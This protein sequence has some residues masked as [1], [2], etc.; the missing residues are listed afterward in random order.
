MASQKDRFVFTREECCALCWANA[1]CHAA[2]FHG[3][4][5]HI[6]GED[7][8]VARN[9]GSVSCVPKRDLESLTATD[10]MECG[11]STICQGPL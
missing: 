6:K 10:T 1:G 2:D 11:A 5:C 3:G 4:V 7:S 8:P 9:D